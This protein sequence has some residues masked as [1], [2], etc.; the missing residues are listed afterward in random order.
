MHCDVRGSDPDLDFTSTA[1]EDW[2]ELRRMHRA[3]S[4]NIFHLIRTVLLYNR[5]NR[6]FLRQSYSILSLLPGSLLREDALPHL[7][8]HGNSM[9]HLRSWPG[10][11]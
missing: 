4:R 6:P 11:R 9:A 3:D 2:R 10:L 1:V 7:R 8:P 5:Q